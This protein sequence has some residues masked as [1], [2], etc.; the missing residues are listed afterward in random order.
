MVFFLDCD[1]RTT[2]PVGLAWRH[3]PIPCR[4]P[5]ESAGRAEPG[6]DPVPPLVHDPGRAVLEIPPRAPR[7]GPHA[8]R[9]DE[10]AARRDGRRRRHVLEH[11]QRRPFVR[12][13]V[14]AGAGDLG[15]VRPVPGGDHGGPG[16]A[17]ALAAP[18]ACSS[19]FLHCGRHGH[20]CAFMKTLVILA[21]LG[22]ILYNLG[23]GLYYMLVDMGTTKRIALSVV[24]ILLVAAGIA[25]GVIEPHGVG[26]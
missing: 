1:S 15:V 12:P 24:L 10:P 2:D 13:H 19:P 20:G 16:R 6:T 23:A 3:L 11:G 21:F 18:P 14:A 5:H 7:L 9:F 17:L 26:S 8:V 25:T 4:C 22:L